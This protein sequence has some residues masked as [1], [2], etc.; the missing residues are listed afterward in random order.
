MRKVVKQVQEYYNQV[1]SDHEGLKLLNADRA[2][3]SFFHLYRYLDHEFAVQHHFYTAY[4]KQTFF[5]M[6]Y[7]TDDE[8][9]FWE[10]LYEVRMKKEGNIFK[11]IRGMYHVNHLPVKCIMHRKFSSIY[12]VKKDIHGIIRMIRARQYIKYANRRVKQY[13]KDTFGVDFS[14]AAGGL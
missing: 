6:D 13:Y 9:S 10:P 12:Q 14:N 8:R 11:Q 1:L 7:L 5:L 2:T 4:F 3:K